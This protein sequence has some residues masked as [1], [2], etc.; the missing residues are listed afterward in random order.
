MAKN[1]TFGE[2]LLEGL[3]EARAWKRGELDLET[4]TYDQFQIGDEFEC[5]GKLYRCTDVGTRTVIAI[6]IDQVEK[7]TKCED[8][9]ITYTTLSRSEAESEGWFNGPPYAVVEHIFD[10]DDLQLCTPPATGL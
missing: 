7:A 1:Q 2:A 9:T 5:E 6:R 8:G 4:V 10:E 3:E